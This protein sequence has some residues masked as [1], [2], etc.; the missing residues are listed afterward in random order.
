M[1]DRKSEIP[2]VEPDLSVQSHRKGGTL[3]VTRAFGYQK[4]IVL[5]NELFGDC[6]SQSKPFFAV[7]G[8]TASMMK[9][10]ENERQCVRRDPD[11]IVCDAHVDMAGRLEDTHLHTPI[12][13]GKADGI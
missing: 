13:R 7:L 2:S 11:S 4:S 12:R 1:A 10:L 8:P 3:S 6:Q 9:R 5:F